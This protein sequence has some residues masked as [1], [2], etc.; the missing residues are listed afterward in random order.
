[1]SSPPSLPPEMLSYQSAMPERRRPIMDGSLAMTC[2]VA[3]AIVSMMLLVVVPHVW[4]AMAP[5]FQDLGMRL[6]AMTMSL[7]GFSRFCQAGGIVAI[8]ILF[9]LPPFIAPRVQAWPPVGPQRRYFRPSR[10]IITLMLTLFCVWV[11]L[12]LVLPYATLIDS[13]ANGPVKK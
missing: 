11:V 13:V 10:L 8:W 3:A 12:G 2:G 9:A 4:V 1:M 7:I 5:T 6:S